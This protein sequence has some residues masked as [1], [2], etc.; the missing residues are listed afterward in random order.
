[1]SSSLSSFLANLDLLVCLLGGWYAVPQL[2]VR[3]EKSFLFSEQDPSLRSSM[4]SD[5][6]VS[7]GSALSCC[8]F[9]VGLGFFTFLGRPCPAFPP[10]PSAFFPC[11]H[12][13]CPPLLNLRSFSFSPCTSGGKVFYHGILY[14]GQA[15]GP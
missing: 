15:S 4:S 2:D 11:I 1:M 10:A 6:E 3:V 12:Q 9:L 13:F 14:Y 8:F 5:D 7:S